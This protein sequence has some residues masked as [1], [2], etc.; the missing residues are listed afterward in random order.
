M[1]L[2]KYQQAWQRQSS[3]TKVTIDADLLLKEVQPSQQNFRTVILLRDFRE[4]GVALAM[5]PIWFFMGYRLSMPWSWYLAVPAM[6]WVAGFIVIHRLRHSKKSVRSDIPLIQCV[7]DS[8]AQVEHQIWL[9]QNVFWW[10]LLPFLIPILA[11]FTHVA[12]KTAKGWLDVVA[13]AV[14]YAIVLGL[15]YLIDLINQWAVRK[16]IGPRRQELIAL[17]DSLEDESKD[18][19]AEKVGGKT[20]QEPKVLRRWAA[21]GVLCVL[22][23]TVIAM[24]R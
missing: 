10:Y 11:F 8:L 9:L 2:D 7:Q 12:L 16:D 1:D 20:I 22:I 13:L 5:I 15:Y 17:R 6:I 19:A 21:I 23:L 18:E 4:V 3:Q 24:T 14:A